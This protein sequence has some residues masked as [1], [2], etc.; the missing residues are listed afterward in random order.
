MAST[1]SAASSIARSRPSGRP[2]PR[3][4]RSSTPRRLAEGWTLA[5]T[6]L[7]EPTVFLDRRLPDPYQ[8]ENYTNKYYETVTL[9]TALEKSANIATVKLLTR[10]G[11]RPVIDSARRLGISAD[12]RPYPSL[13]LGSFEVTL[14]ELTSAYGAFANQGVL[15]EPHFSSRRCATATAHWSRRSSPRS[16]TPSAPRSPT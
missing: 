10:I 16:T 3:S 12:L 9:R 4:S 11:Y 1:S 14:L 6:L 5:D 15:V 2:A 13:A 7:D 8:P